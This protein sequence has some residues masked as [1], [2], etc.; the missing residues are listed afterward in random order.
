MG[1]L[2]PLI[3]IGAQLLASEQE[4][5]HNKAMLPA[6]LLAA[7]ARKLGVGTTQFDTQKALSGMDAGQQIQNYAPAIMQ[8]VSAMGQS[9]GP[10]ETSKEELAEL[11]KQKLEGFRTQPMRSYEF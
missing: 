9:G 10:S 4:K 3:S 8:L 6:E 1:P 5:Q 11:Q 2:I 7:R